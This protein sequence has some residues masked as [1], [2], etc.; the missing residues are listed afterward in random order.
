MN[1]NLINRK[2]FDIVAF[3]EG[4]IPDN[5]G[6]MVSEIHGY[7]PFKLEFKHDY[8]QRMFPT[9]EHSSFDR[10]AHV[11]TESEITSIRDSQGAKENIRKMYNIMLRFWKIDGDRYM[12]W[13]IQ[14][15]WNHAHN[16]NH[17]RMTRLLLCFQLLGLDSEYAD[18]SKRL[19]Y[20][21]NM[22]NTQKINEKAKGKVCISNKT[23][24]I[25]S[26]YISHF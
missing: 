25:W 13:T 22:R 21:I 11:L 5:K 24:D 15:H 26:R 7:G 12:D 10:T 2:N 17:Y 4:R 19:S 8:I 9:D 3:L 23:C 1:R 20:M 6:R 18:L 16:H 14:R